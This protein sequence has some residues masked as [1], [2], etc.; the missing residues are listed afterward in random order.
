MKVVGKK[1]S[2]CLSLCGISFNKVE[3]YVWK[4]MIQT[5][6]S[7]ARSH[8][9][10]LDYCGPSRYQVTEVYVPEICDAVQEE[11]KTKLIPSIRRYGYEILVDGYS[12]RTEPMHNV[13]IQSNG[14]TFFMGAEP[15]LDATPDAKH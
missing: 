7:Y 15:L 8:Q 14:M 2:L 5:I 12:T 3:K 1:I 10:P 11:I 13:L 4:D 9:L 6:V